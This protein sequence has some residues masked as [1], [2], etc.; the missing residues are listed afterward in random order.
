MNTISITPTR[1]SSIHNLNFSKDLL[2][3]FEKSTWYSRYAST[4]PTTPFIRLFTLRSSSCGK[5]MFLHLSVIL[6]TGRGSSM[7]GGGGGM[8][9][10]GGC[11]A[12]SVW[13]GDAW[14]G[15]GDAWQGRG[16]A[17]QG[18]AWQ[19]RGDAWQGVH[20]RGVCMRGMRDRHCSRRYPSYW[21]AFLFINYSF[22]LCSRRKYMSLI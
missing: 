11:V 17:W 1:R 21:N 2:K 6:F 8:C 9:E 20:G 15:R 10:G 19:G 13:Q 16:D 18:G 7:A 22:I 4:S 3:N 14:Q 12:G 5:V